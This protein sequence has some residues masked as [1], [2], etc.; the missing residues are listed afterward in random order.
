MMSELWPT[1]RKKSFQ[2]PRP[3]LPLYSVITYS[4]HDSDTNDGGVRV[5]GVPLTWAVAWKKLDVNEYLLNYV[6]DILSNR[7][8]RN[9]VGY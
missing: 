1:S 3:S 9:P 4:M 7:N 8:A 2:L 6:C 5:F